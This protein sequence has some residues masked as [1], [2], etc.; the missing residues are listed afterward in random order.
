M[1]SYDAKM[2]I[3]SSKMLIF[4]VNSNLFRF[5]RANFSGCAALF[6]E[7]LCFSVSHH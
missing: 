7:K 6:A 4:G 5:N 3:L 1:W 2:G